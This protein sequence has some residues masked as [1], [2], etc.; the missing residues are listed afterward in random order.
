M[1]VDIGEISLCN[2]WDVDDVLNYL[3]YFLIFCEVIQILSYDF[4]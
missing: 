4:E 3:L 1:V 2:V